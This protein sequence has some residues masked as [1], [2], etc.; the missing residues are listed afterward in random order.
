[1]FIRKVKV[2]R[3]LRPI[4]AR[5]AKWYQLMLWSVKWE[6]R[7]KKKIYL[8]RKRA[9]KNLYNEM[10]IHQNYFILMGLKLCS[11]PFLWSCF[12]C[13]AFPLFHKL[14]RAHTHI[15]ISVRLW[16]NE[17]Q[18]YQSICCFFFL[19]F[20]LSSPFVD[21]SI[22]INQMKMKIKE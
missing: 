6:K 7:I 12:F 2:I 20:S 9:I 8:R 18:C 5:I 21:S 10:Q 22:L 4:T 11:P 3:S 15:H 16:M 1:M 13:S 17:I 19:F 14:T